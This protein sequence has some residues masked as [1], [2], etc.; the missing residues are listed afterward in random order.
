MM[1]TNSQV[2]FMCTTEG[3][4]VPLVAT[5]VDATLH[6]LLA[7]VTMTQV[8][9]NSEER[10]IEAVYTFPLPLDAVLLDLEITLNDRKLKGA[11]VGKKE[12]EEQYE[13]AISD[14]N[15]AIMLQKIEAGLY[16]MNIGNLQPG[17][18]IEVAMRYSLLH[19]WQGDQLRFYLPTTVAPKYGLV[20]LEPHQIP[21]ADLFAE[22]KFGFRLKVT[23]LLREAEFES[24]SHVIINESQHDHRLIRL[25]N[26]MTLMDRDLI[27]NI[28]SREQTM[29]SA[30]YDSDGDGFVSLV[31]FKP[32][33]PHSDDS[34]PHAMTIVVDCSGSMDGDSIAQAKIALQ[35]ILESLKSSDLFNILF[36]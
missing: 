35:R 4:Q 7:D 32:M 5:I 3:E 20:D 19:R 14:G 23:G 13:E 26:E 8:Y 11:V 9:K 34:K 22:N 33:I 28:R 18:R 17:E 29:A 1:T 30:V 12:A 2:S 16:S 15:S 6:D 25:R 31:S 24:P 36:G 27:I 21:E 10:N